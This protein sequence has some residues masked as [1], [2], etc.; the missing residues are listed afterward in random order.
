MWRT[1][2]LSQNFISCDI[3]VIYFCTYKDTSNV[4]FL[5]IYTL[6]LAFYDKRP[7]GDVCACVSFNSR[8]SIL[9]LYFFSNVGRVDLYIY[10]TVI[11][12]LSPMEL[13]YVHISMKLTNSQSSNAF[14]LYFL[15]VFL[16]SPLTMRESK[17]MYFEFVCK[18]IL[19]ETKNIATSTLSLTHPRSDILDVWVKETE[20]CT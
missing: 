18:N 7:G 6:Y 2:D 5:I 19:Q 3:H 12:S 16:I 14:E 8:L 1:R 15:D 20:T 4:C 11:S 9:I 13:F 17:K 10:I